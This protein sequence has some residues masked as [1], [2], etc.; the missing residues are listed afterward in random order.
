MA[1][2]GI[3]GGVL[4]LLA[5]CASEQGLV[6]NEHIDTFVQTP[7]DQVDILFVIDDSD[8]MLQEQV[9]LAEGFDSFA[10]ALDSADIDFHLGVI[11]TSQPT[12]DPQSGVL[13]GSPRYLTKDDD[14]VKLFAERA[15]IGVGGRQKEK[16]LQAAVHA[17]APHMQIQENL[18]FLRDQAN[19]L[20][21]FVSDE[22]DCSDYGLLDDAPPEACYRDK[23]LLVP[24]TDMVERLR[25][26]KELGGHLQ[27]SGIV[28]P[29]DGS[30]GEIA[31]AGY[32]YAEAA[33]QTGG[34]LNRICEEDWSGILGELGLN[35]LGI[36]ERF[37][38]THAADPD[39]I[40][41]LVDDEPVFRDG[42]RGWSYDAANWVVS[43]HGPSVPE[44]GARIVIRY[45]VAPYAGEPGAA[46][47]APGGSG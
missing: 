25:G 2:R 30:C 43:F 31:L 4:G 9:A 36:L 6:S 5:A 33:L 47:G 40:E 38:L 29:F 46:R 24:V 14:Y 27:I 34:T 23:H 44:R 8:S 37:Q 7:T 3:T 35:A 41:I 22:D 21:V 12:G 45:I 17:L 20:I 13:E 11:S 28:G 39:T 18:G 42:A 32:R 19:L 16:G 10:D 26:Y 15:A 1:M